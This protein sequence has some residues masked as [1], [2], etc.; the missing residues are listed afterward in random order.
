M[1]NKATMTINRSDA[2]EPLLISVAD[3]PALTGL[4]LS[5]AKAHVA[6]GDIPSIKLGRRR[7]VPLAGLRSWMER[8]L[9][10]DDAP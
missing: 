8:H 10:A 2:I 4:G 1:F 5:T 9:A 3:I 6:S 7:L